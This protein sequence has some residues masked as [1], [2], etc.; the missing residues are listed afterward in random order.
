M[1]LRRVVKF[2]QPFVLFFLILN[3]GANGLFVGSNAGL[4]LTASRDASS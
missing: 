2:V 3:V 1:R 4:P